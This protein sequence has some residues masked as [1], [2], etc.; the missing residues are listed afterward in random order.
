[1]IGQLRDIRTQILIVAGLLLVADL[2]AGVMLMSPAGRA[3][4]AHM[5]EFERLR[6]ERREKTEAAAPVRNL[7]K[8]IE[9]ARLQEAAFIED[10]LPHRYSS[11]SEELARLAQESG[12][13]VTDIKY[14]ES[15]AR[16]KT[17]PAGFTGIGIAL[18]AHG[19][20]EQDMR[21]INSVERQKLLML[22]DSVSFGG[23]QNGTLSVSLHLSTYMRSQP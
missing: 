11:M 9:E 19:G 22:I 15:Q 6:V 10:R 1:M 21:F 13:H 4:A 8:N 12:I 17:L 2:G 23:V 16:D 20:Y 5:Q 14:D 18:A 3:R 7:D